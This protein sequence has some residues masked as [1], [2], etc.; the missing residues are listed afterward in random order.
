MPA[1]TAASTPSVGSLRST[2]RQYGAARRV[3]G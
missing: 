1:K 3:Q 2:R